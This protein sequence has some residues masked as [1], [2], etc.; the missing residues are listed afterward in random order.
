MVRM[1]Q[2]LKEA[3]E[4]DRADQAELVASL[5]EKLEEP[6]LQVSDAETQARLA[7]LKSGKVAALSEADFWKACGR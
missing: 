3:S 6:F 5:L 4:L 2:L 1:E 7:D